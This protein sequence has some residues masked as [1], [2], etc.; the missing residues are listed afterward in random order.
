MKG[1]AENIAGGCNS[2]NDNR[3]HLI[4]ND[5]LGFVIVEANGLEGVDAEGM[6]IFHGSTGVN[7]LKCCCCYC[8]LSCAGSCT[9][10][11]QA[12]VPIK[13]IKQY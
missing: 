3:S 2:R 6:V 11:P 9:H 7:V 1:S 10:N 13:I 8:L 12:T 4:S 5:R